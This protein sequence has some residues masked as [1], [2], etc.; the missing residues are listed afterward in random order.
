M[1]EAVGKTRPAPKYRLHFPGE[2][3]DPAGMVIPPPIVALR[4]T[5]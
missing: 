4:T 1:M 5:G 3:G 2:L